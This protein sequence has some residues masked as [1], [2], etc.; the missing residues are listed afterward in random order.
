MFID[1]SKISELRKAL[2]VDTTLNSRVEVPTKAKRNPGGI[3]E[4]RVIIQTQGPDHIQTVKETIEF[5]G[6]NVAGM[7]DHGKESKRSIFQRFL[8]RIWLTFIAVWGAIMATGIAFTTQETP[9]LLTGS[10]AIPVAF[11]IASI[12]FL[13]R[14]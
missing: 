12:D 3:S 4:I 13:R 7:L 5:A 14:R 2:K 9:L 10:V 1:Y 6:G 8:K 11:G